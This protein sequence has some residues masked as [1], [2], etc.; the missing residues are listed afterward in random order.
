VI[1]ETKMRDARARLVWVALALAVIT[2]C[3]SLASA[4]PEFFA[5]FLAEYP[6]VVG[7]RLESCLVC[8]TEPPR[9]NPYGTDFNLAGRD[10]SAI[11]PLDSDGDGFDNL[12]EIQ[13]L[14]FPGN[15][16]DNPNSSP[17]PTGSPTP[18]VATG[19]TSTPKSTSTRAPTPTIVPGPCYGDCDGNGAVAINE[20]VLGVN[21][22]LEKAAVGECPL[23]DNDNSGSVSVDE[24]VKAVNRALH[25]CPA[26]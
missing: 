21:I 3:P 20:L 9:R 17:I 5:A 26:Q 25:G 16:S 2:I 7:T 4:K 22:A 8:H 10:F 24:L 18:T 14:T 11:E 23:A 1:E 6:F 19:P 13:A 12:T 15:A